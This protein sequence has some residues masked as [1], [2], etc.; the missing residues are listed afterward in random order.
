M[1]LSNGSLAIMET[2]KSLTN[3]VAKAISLRKATLSQGTETE[4]R[5]SVFSCHFCFWCD[6]VQFFQRDIM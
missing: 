3:I 6:V 4:N 1:C 2:R 5:R